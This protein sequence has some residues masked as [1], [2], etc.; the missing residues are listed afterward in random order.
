MPV[1][2]ADEGGGGPSGDQERCGIVEVLSSEVGHAV[3]DAEQTPEPEQHDERRGVDVID[4]RWV[5]EIAWEQLTGEH[6][7]RRGPR[8]VQVLEC[9]YTRKAQASPPR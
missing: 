2:A 6:A 4:Q 3:P 9:R 8:L 1:R 7:D 5:D